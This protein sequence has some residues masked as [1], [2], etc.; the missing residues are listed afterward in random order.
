[1]HTNFCRLRPHHGP[2]NWRHCCGLGRWYNNSNQWRHKRIGI[3]SINCSS[4]VGDMHA[5]CRG[6]SAFDG[7]EIQRH[8]CRL[9]KQWQWSMH[10]ASHSGNMH[11]N[12][13]GSVS[14]RGYSKQRLG[15]CM[16][17][18]W[19][20]TMHRASHIRNVHANCAWRLSLGCA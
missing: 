8:R 13:R 14:Q 10:R 20:W 16:G 17:Q 3:W 9:G 4:H 12:C 7:S 19:Q 5:N 18:Q 11:Q 15:R 1:M 6:W 2:T